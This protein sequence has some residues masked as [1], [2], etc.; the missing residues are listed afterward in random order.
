MKDR[1]EQLVKQGHLTAFEADVMRTAKSA[2]EKAYPRGPGSVYL[3]NL[4][5]SIKRNAETDWR[6]PYLALFLLVLMLYAVAFAKAVYEGHE[7]NRQQV[8]EEMR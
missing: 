2:E 1:F 4:G 6:N 7:Y 5:Q 3:H 8:T